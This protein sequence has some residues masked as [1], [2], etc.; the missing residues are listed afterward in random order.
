MCIDKNELDRQTAEAIANGTASPIKKRRGFAAISPERQREIA[1]KGG[2][3]VAPEKRSYSQD[4][5]LARSAGSSGGRS[6]PGES[7]SFSRN[8]SLASQAG[9]K[10]GIQRGENIRTRKAA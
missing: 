7:R 10:G 2:K 8:R 1:S 9:R 5:S 6:V 4:R 3:S